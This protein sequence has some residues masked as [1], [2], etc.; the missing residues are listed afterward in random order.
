MAIELR[1]DREVTL[2][3]LTHFYGCLLSRIHELDA[4]LKNVPDWTVHRFV[5][6]C[7]NSSTAHFG[8][9]TRLRKTQQSL[10]RLIEQFQG[11][12]MF[13][14]LKDVLNND[15]QALKQ[16]LLN[17][18]V[19]D[20][21]TYFENLRERAARI[22]WDWYSD[23]RGDVKDSRS[24][25]IPIYIYAGNERKISTVL[26]STQGSVQIAFQFNPADFPFEFYLGLPIYLTHEYLSHIYRYEFFGGDLENPSHIFEDGWLYFIAFRLIG[27]DLN[28]EASQYMNKE[29][30]RWCF[31]DLERQAEIATSEVGLG[32]GTAKKLTVAIGKEPFTLISRIVARC[33]S[34]DK[35]NNF[36]TE[37]VL[38][39]QQALNNPGYEN[40]KIKQTLGS[41]M[42]EAGKLLFGQGKYEDGKRSLDLAAKLYP[43]GTDAYL[44]TL[45]NLYLG[46][47]NLAD[48][49]EAFVKS[50]KKNS[51]NW[52]S[53][54]GESVIE[55]IKG[56]PYGALE[57]V[58]SGLMVH[59]QQKQL[60]NQKGVVLMQMGQVEQALEAVNQ[61]LDCDVNYLAALRNKLLI[62]NNLD[63]RN[64]ARKIQIAID[65][66]EQQVLSHL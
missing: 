36:H 21:L 7:V 49:H 18:P 23:G 3:I 64:E 62:L 6:E 2:N 8:K 19:E 51:R 52:E 28:V 57:L 4:S 63:L 46:S 38:S 60:W 9:E 44:A 29:V 16:D 31:E 50:L 37:F 25:Q 35:R 30:I 59:S 33:P 34:I 1:S 14:G 22:A 56:N 5:T 15:V 45:G 26:S 40:R 17:R 54:L 53:I 11:S 48:A 47:G 61:A 41:R 65:A 39:V 32:F 27:R 24:S 43:E 55:S 58:N 66:I 42:Q 10:E 12:I 20:A 13:H